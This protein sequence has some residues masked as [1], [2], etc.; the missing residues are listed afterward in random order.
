MSEKWDAAARCA[1]D[2][3]P[4]DAIAAIR[5]ELACL[6]TD[7]DHAVHYSYRGG[8]SMACD[9]VTTRIVTLSRVAGATPWSEVPIPLVL[10]GTWAGILTSAGIAFEEPGPD[11]MRDMREWREAQVLRARGG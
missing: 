5:E 6:W 10:D 9:W 1:D 7:L 4:A 3:P 8:W 2:D 11:D